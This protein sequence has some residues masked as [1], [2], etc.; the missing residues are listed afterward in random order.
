MKVPEKRIKQALIL[1]TEAIVEESDET[2]IYI[3]KDDKA[4]K[5]KIKVKETQSDKTAIEG[6]VEKG[7]Q[8][9]VNGQLT[10]SDGDKVKVVNESE[11]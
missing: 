10:L 3:M 4:V 8:I 5:T 11:E 6:E 1:P 2:F 9:I 7:D